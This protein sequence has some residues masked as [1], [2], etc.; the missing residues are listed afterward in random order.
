MKAESLISMTDICGILLDKD[1][2]STLVTNINM[3]KA[4]NLWKAELSRAE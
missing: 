2:P 4:R 1:D 3:E